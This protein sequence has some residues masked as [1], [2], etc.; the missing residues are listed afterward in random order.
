MSNGRVDLPPAYDVSVVTSGPW[1]TAEDPSLRIP[2]P[3]ASAVAIWSV[4]EG[5]SVLLVPPAPGTH[6]VW[7]PISFRLR[8]LRTVHAVERGAM[9]F[10]D[11][12]DYVVTAAEA[13]GARTLVGFSGDTDVLRQAGIDASVVDLILVL[14]PPGDA[15]P[16]RSDA[17]RMQAVD[18]STNDAES[19]SEADAAQLIAHLS[20]GM[21]DR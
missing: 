13:V 16:V 18:V 9:S 12:V 3:A 1:W 20:E 14:S 5:P 21:V 11:D 4:G 2:R 15:V 6:D 19:L 10:A 8:H 17:V 7:A